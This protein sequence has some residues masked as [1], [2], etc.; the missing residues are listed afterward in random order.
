MIRYR[1][2][3]S[4]PKSKLSKNRKRKK[5]CTNVNLSNQDN[6]NIILQRKKIKHA[7]AQ[8]KYFSTHKGKIALASAKKA[9]Y[10]TAEGK[11]VIAK[12]QETYFNTM[13]GKSALARSQE[14]YFNTMKGKSALAR[15]QEAYFNTMKGKSALARS[16]ETYFNTLKGK[17]SLASA[18]K[19][20]YD[21][22]EGKHVL[23]K[24]QEAYFNTLKGKSALARSQEAYF[25][26]DNGR[27]KLTEAQKAYYSTGKGKRA[28]YGAH[29][30]YASTIKG[31]KAKYRYRSS[32]KAK[33][34]M[35]TAKKSYFSTAKGLHIKKMA[36]KRYYHSIH[37]QASMEKNADKRLIHL[38]G[39]L[40]KVV[41]KVH[42][43]NSQ[44]VTKASTKA[45]NEQDSTDNDAY[46]CNLND[47]LKCIRDHKPSAAV[48]NRYNKDIKKKLASNRRTVNPP[49]KI[50]APSEICQS[51]FKNLHKK[52]ISHVKSQALVKFIFHTKS[53]LKSEFLTMTTA[54]IKEKASLIC[55]NFMCNK[56]TRE[57]NVDYIL[58]RLIMDYL[59]VH[60]KWVTN[61]AY[62]GHQSK[63]F[64]EDIFDKLALTED[65]DATGI[66]LGKLVHSKNFIP[67]FP[68]HSFKDGKQ[69]NFKKKDSIVR[70]I[71]KSH[72]K[73]KDKTDST[74]N[75]SH[76]NVLDKISNAESKIKLLTENKEYLC[77]ENC[78]FASENEIR[79]LKY[80][81]EK[82][83]KTDYKSFREVIEKFDFCANEHSLNVLYRLNKSPRNHPNE[84]FFDNSECQSEF[85]LL[86]KLGVHSFNVRKMYE[87]LN[88]IRKAH[89]V[90]SDLDTALVLKDIDYLIK[91][92]KYIPVVKSKVV[93]I[94]ERQSRIVNEEIIIGRFEDHYLEYVKAVKDLPQFTCI[95]CEILVRPTEAKIISSRRKKLDNDKFTQLKQYLCS[96]QR[97]SMG[98]EII[99]SIFNRY[100]CNY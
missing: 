78:T 81:L 10:D 41:D 96:E 99:D 51:I 75:T 49:L 72:V 33:M 22:A 18:K 84:C 53:W 5:Q 35:Y 98:K 29:K 2:A 9:Y 58:E 63:Q 36:N 59:H 25:N 28:V 8:K 37:D 19:T 34:R 85:V 13:K 44:V 27:L 61:L 89:N 3:G 56:G 82:C 57:A 32:T 43:S 26:T 69:Y 48:F 74:N 100:L 24:S 95:S 1:T 97:E 30:A 70:E 77:D 6:Q 91:L 40:N 76:E 67:F 62:C 11:H 86:R 94:T 68:Q 47:I 16:Q 52:S 92:T 60:E 45:C 80:C 46:N 90:L 21:T 17:S 73:V 31:I 12:S 88:L 64:A 14:A 50:I 93:T 7:Q 39:A 15:S 38:K 54:D 20:Y 55:P 71:C 83:S 42:N 79:N 66:M 65:K 23:A 87:K 4:R